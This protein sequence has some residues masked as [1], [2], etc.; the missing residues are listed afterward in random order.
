MRTIVLSLFVSITGCNTFNLMTATVDVG[1]AELS[2]VTIRVI[3]TGG[4]E[5][6]IGEGQVR[7]NRETRSVDSEPFVMFGDVK[8]EIHRTGTVRQLRVNGESYG[9]VTAKDKVVVTE[10]RRVEVNGEERAPSQ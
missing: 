6:V 4:A 1:V 10:D 3:D 9:E 2:D 7:Y 5:G 8:V